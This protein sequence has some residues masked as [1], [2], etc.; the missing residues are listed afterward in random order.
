MG[1]DTEAIRTLREKRGMTLEQAAQAAGLSNR[2]HW[3]QIE[4]G[5]KPNLTVATLEKIA[6]ALGVKAKDLLK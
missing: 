3:H 2:Q 1:V 6:A 5:S 4:N